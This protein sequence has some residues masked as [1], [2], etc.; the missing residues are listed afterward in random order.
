RPDGLLAGQWRLRHASRRR[1]GAR[2]LSPLLRRHAAVTDAGR[3]GDDA[4][5]GR[6]G[7][8]AAAAQGAGVREVRQERCGRSEPRVPRLRLPGTVSRQADR[9]LPRACSVALTAASRTATSGAT[10]GA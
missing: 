3:T 2:R 10:P 7:V 1:C 4:A 6:T 8:L 9:V 5:K